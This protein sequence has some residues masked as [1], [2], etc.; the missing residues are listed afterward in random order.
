MS[1]EI[2]EDLV[3]DGKE[4]V[5]PAARP[6]LYDRTVTVSGL[7]KAYSITGW[8]L[9]WLAAPRAL[10]SAIGPVF[11]VLCVCAPRPLQAAAATALAEL[12]ETYYRTARDGYLVRR[13]RLAAALRDAGF[14]RGCLGR[15]LHDGRLPGPLRRHPDARCLLSPARRDPSPPFGQR[16]LLPRGRVGSVVRFRSPSDGRLLEGSSGVSGGGA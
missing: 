1:D 9:G 12:P 6:A 13:D 7:S 5:P 8:R 14:A 16:D 2:Y 4:H 11:D 15:V 10:S 3:Y